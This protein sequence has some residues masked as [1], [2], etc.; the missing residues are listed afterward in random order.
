MTNTEFETQ[1]LKELKEI[2]TDVS[3]LKTD[4]SGLKTDMWEVKTEIQDLH[5]KFDRLDDRLDEVNTN[6]TQEIRLQGAYLNQAFDRMSY[7]QQ[8]KQKYSH[9]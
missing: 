8:T 3:G 7:M 4:V 6:L 9:K 5:Q 2:K 1:V